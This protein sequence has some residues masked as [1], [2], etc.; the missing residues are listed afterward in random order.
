MEKHAVKAGERPESSL[1]RNVLAMLCT[2]VWRGE[3]GAAR[4]T[5]TKTLGA[6][7]IVAKGPIPTGRSYQESDVLYCA[8]EE[9]FLSGVRNEV[10]GR[11]PLPPQSGLSLHDR[12]VASI[13][14]LLFEEIDSGGVSGALYVESLAYAL[15]VR[16]LL[17]G[18]RPAVQLTSTTAKIPQRK[19]FRVQELIENHLGADLTLEELANEIGYSRSHFLRLF[20][21]TTGMTPHRYVLKRRIE[22]ARLLLRGGDLS[23]AEVAIACGFSSQAHLTLA[24]RKQC[25]LTPAEY[26]RCL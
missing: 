6:L 5:F 18:D 12:A 25:G 4:G 20:R 17:L 10:E 15:A 3:H 8:F 19:L 16:F 21:A 24:F 22:Q 7:T 9:P 1:D 26:R 14:N 11:L 13:L 23:I 2:P